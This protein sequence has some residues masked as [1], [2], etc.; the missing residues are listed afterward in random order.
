ML[1]ENYDLKSD[2]SS[3]LISDKNIEE[4]Y[5]FDEVIDY[6]ENRDEY[7]FVGI[8]DKE[9]NRRKNK[10]IDEVNDVFKIR[11]KRD[12][13]LEKKRGTGIP[14]LKGAVCATSKQ[15]EYLESLAKDLGITI[16]NKDVTRTDLCNN[17]MEKL[18]EL[19]KYSKGKNKITYIMIPNNH[20]KY[21]FPLNIEDRITYVKD[22]VSK[23][24]SKNIKFKENIKN[25]EMEIK[26]K[27]EKVLLNLILTN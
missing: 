1:N 21:K 11:E 20:P 26:F 12:K 19:E 17:I 9:E 5:N 18:I 27:I 24:L 23:L 4:G 10:R 3:D 25:K 22:S 13:I 8:I 15:K 6:Y 2:L 14:S 16:K 7:K